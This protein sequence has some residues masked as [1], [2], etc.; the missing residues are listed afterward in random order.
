MEIYLPENWKNGDLTPWKLEFTLQKPSKNATL[1]LKQQK[2]WSFTT[3]TSAFWTSKMV[4]FYHRKIDVS[5]V[6]HQKGGVWFF[7]N[8]R[9]LNQ[10][11]ICQPTWSI[12]RNWRKHCTS[13]G[14]RL[15]YRPWPWK[16]EEI[17][18]WSC[19]KTSENIMFSNIRLQAT[20]TTDRCITKLSWYNIGK[21]TNSI[22]D[23][24]YLPKQI[25]TWWTN[26]VWMGPWQ[27]YNC[28][29]SFTLV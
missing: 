8:R 20:I 12:F 7:T 26:C 15:V 3:K 10:R 5:T 14:Y 9:G 23:Q 29:A 27:P 21:Q 22:D 2:W 17:S 24:I 11:Y 13:W 18:T 25:R 6:Y 19:K 1:G 16:L 4:E 28:S